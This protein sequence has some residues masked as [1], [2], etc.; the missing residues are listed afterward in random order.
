MILPPIDHGAAISRHACGNA[1]EAGKRSHLG[2]VRN[3]VSVSPT[4]SSTMGEGL[5]GLLL[6]TEFLDLAP[7]RLGEAERSL[8]GVNALPRTRAYVHAAL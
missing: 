4:V 1:A 2:Q 7:D 3:Q 6:A 5:Q 8:I